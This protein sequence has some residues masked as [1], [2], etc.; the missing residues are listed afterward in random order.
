M[1]P[2]DA[3]RHLTPESLRAALNVNPEDGAMWMHLGELLHRLQDFGEARDALETASMLVPLSVDAQLALADCYCRLGD[4]DLAVFLYDAITANSSLAGE[5]LAR[6]ASA[7]GSMN[8]H[9]RALSVCRTLTSREPDCHEAYFGQA[10]Y[11]RKLGA[12]FPDVEPLL[13]KAFELSPSMPL[14]RITLAALYAFL[15]RRQEA[16]DLLVDVEPSAVGCRCCIT[17]VM[18]ILSLHGDRVSLGHWAKQLNE[19][20]KLQ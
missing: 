5:V 4:R 3:T 13:L 19:V 9:E 20:G 1:R 6:V 10:F 14:Y 15:G 16:Y 12:P 11:L 7:L 17:R 18:S 8:E 2:G